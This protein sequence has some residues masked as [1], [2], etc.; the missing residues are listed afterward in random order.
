M[1][2]IRM[3][4]LF[5]TK[6]T[7]RLGFS[8]VEV[9][10]V[11][12]VM[13]TVTAGAIFTLVNINQAAQNTKLQR[14][15]M[16]VNNAI[17]IYLMSGGT[18]SASDL[19]SP[20]TLLDKLKKRT[21]A[22]SAKQMAGLRGGMADERLTYE[23]QSEAEASSGAERARFVAD[24][25]N[26]RFVI[27]KSG[28]AGIRRFVL[29]VSLATKDFGTEERAATMKLAK[30]DPWVWD[31]KDTGP[32]RA[33]PGLPPST[34][35]GTTNPNPPDQGN[36]TLNPP[37]FSVAGGTTALTTFPK[38]VAL[39][40]TNPA[41]TAQILYS[42]NNGPFVPYSGPVT[43]DP[44][45]SLT[46]VSISMDPDHYDDSA[47]RSETYK[48][49]PVKPWPFML[50]GEDS[51]T[52][53]EL[54]G[55]AAPGT[56][57]PSP[58]GSVS[59][60]GFILNMLLIPKAYRNSSVFRY[61]W[62]TDG[63]NPLSSTTALL[64]SDFTDGFLSTPIG[65]PLSAFGSSSS[66]TVTSGV[67][68]INKAIVTD[69][70]TVDQVI[71]VSRID[72]RKPMVSIDGRDVT[73]KLDVSHRDMPKGARIYY[74]TDGT[75]PGADANKNPL[76]GTLYSGAPFTLTGSTGSEV[77][78]KARV[79]PPVGYPQFFKVSDQESRKLDLPAATDVY[80][81]GNFINSSGNPMRNVARLN[82]SGQVDT[83]FN[84]GNGASDDSLV[85]IIRQT[86]NGV[87]AGG[88]FESMNGSPRQGLVRLNPNG[89]V[90]NS[91]DADL[92]AN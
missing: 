61:A 46:G 79:Y 14:D 73:L 81:G 37:D 33:T 35:P 88:D 49:T 90:D 87:M 47:S 38:P 21:T 30:K 75:D 72:L 4:C 9:L 58:S 50:F 60:S 39:V 24:L 53:F 16:V 70:D 36:L 65:L 76:R 51:Y 13:S 63:T 52:Y 57:A 86:P 32:G 19:E 64:Q 48:T 82:N 41:G 43:V 45:Q 91:F 56:P 25:T 71:D 55:E 84:T 29:D 74:T 67:R 31:Y 7:A 34:S 1:A 62:T 78:I 22:E 66:V 3:K 44:G 83:R 6:P 42:L 18:F 26:P 77:T 11:V 69:S 10:M 85:G 15:V 20:A 80:V 40:P 17:R 27:Q 8:L 89:S 68:A 12:A 23:M 54:G 59:G 5:T 92:T 28:A 2:I